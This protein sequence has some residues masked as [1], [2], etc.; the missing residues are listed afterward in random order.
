MKVVINIC[1]GGFGVS[2]AGVVLL[3]VMG[4]KAA[5]KEKLNKEGSIYDDSYL[6]V[7]DRIDKDLIKIVE[8]S[9]EAASGKYAKLAV[10]QIPDDVDWYIDDYDGLEHVAEKHRTWQA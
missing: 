9:S 3:K 10:V 7:I 2:R 4:N 5:L 8:K 1:H 6:R